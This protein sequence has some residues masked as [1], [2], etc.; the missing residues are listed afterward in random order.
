[1]QA[2]P[3]CFLHEKIKVSFEKPMKLSN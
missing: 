3:M 2:A 1:M